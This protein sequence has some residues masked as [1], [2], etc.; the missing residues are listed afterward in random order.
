MKTTLPIALCLS[1]IMLLASCYGRKELIIA[2]IPERPV[3]TRPG[4]PG[5]NYEWAEGDWIIKKGNYSW[6]KG[7]WKQTK[8]KVW[9][10]GNWIPKNHGW[11]WQRG[12]WQRREFPIATGEIVFQ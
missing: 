11:A 2:K 1:V 10:E 4:L 5:N 8:K 7:H 3:Y 9:V 12:H 6:K